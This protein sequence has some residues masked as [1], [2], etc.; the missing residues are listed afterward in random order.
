MKSIKVIVVSKKGRQFIINRSDTAE[1]A[2]GDDSKKVAS[3]FCR[4]R[5]RGDTLSGRPG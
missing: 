2:D 1:M 5:H 4:K 3:F